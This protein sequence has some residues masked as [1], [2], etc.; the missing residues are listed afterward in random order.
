[1]HKISVELNG[2]SIE[3][4]VENLQE[5]FICP[6][7]SKPLSELKVTE[8]RKLKDARVCMSDVSPTD[9]VSGYQ[10]W[11][12]KQAFVPVS[13]ISDMEVISVQTALTPFYNFTGSVRVTWKGSRTEHDSKGKPYTHQLSGTTNQDFDVT[14]PAQSATPLSD[15]MQKVK[16][17]EINNGSSIPFD[18]E[19]FSDIANY[20][21]VYP[22]D[23]AKHAL[24]TKAQPMIN[25]IGKDAAKSACDGTVSSTNIKTTVD[26]SELILALTYIITYKYQ[27]KTYIGA[28]VPEAKAGMGSYPISKAQKSINLVLNVL[29]LAIAAAV[30]FYVGFSDSD[31]S[32]LITGAVFG[33]AVFLVLYVLKR[34]VAWFLR[35]FR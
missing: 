9:G 10:S 4:C 27:G 18:A 20:V 19:M 12:K 15:T 5:G 34:I 25:Q 29:I 32:T 26:A 30:A 31:G 6:F 28:Y 11:L 16:L 2:K 33:I 21:I 24:K 23:D 13:V 1:M 14:V 7:S 17:H 3:Y 35:F 22:S 8:I